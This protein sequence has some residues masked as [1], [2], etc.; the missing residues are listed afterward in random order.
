MYILVQSH[1]DVCTHHSQSPVKMA[2]ISDYDVVSRLNN[3][4]TSHSFFD[5]FT[6]S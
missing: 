5:H 2:N 4:M 6:H 3:M 1:D